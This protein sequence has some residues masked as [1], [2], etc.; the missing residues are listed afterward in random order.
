MKSWVE[1]MKKEA[2]LKAKEAKDEKTLRNRGLKANHRSHV[3][4]AFLQSIEMK[5]HKGMKSWLRNRKT[6]CKKET[7]NYTSKKSE[8][9]ST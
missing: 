9:G 6:I 4:K 2:E 5:F 1:K 3:P 8:S 7:E